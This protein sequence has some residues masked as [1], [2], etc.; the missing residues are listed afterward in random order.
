MI[1]SSSFEEETGL[2]GTVNPAHSV[3]GGSGEPSYSMSDAARF[4]HTFLDQWC[5][6]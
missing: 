4:K 2:I 3:C 1:S 6:N 5:S